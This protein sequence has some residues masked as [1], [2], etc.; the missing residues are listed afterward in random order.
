MVHRGRRP[1][2]S[3][4]VNHATSGGLESGKS[5]WRRRMTMIPIESID[6]V[7]ELG[8]PFYPSGCHEGEYFS[9]PLI[10]QLLPCHSPGVKTSRDADLVDIEGR[11]SRSED[12]PVLQP[13]RW[14]CSRCRQ[15]CRRLMS[16]VARFDPIQTRKKLQLRGLAPASLRA[17]LSTVRRPVGVLGSGDEAT[18][19]E[20]TRVVPEVAAGQSVLDLSAAG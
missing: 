9:W 11:A 17:L 13:G 1:V 10:T 8:L 18:R 16:T 15:G 3:A 7:L 12:G 14:R 4:T 19:R 20:A 2:G 6:Q 5:C